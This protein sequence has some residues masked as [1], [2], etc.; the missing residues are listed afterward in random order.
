MNK[1]N[2]DAVGCVISLIAAAVVLL[3]V[4]GAVWWGWYK[5]SVQA[6]V[7]RREGIEMTT[8]E[9]WTGAKPAERT[10]NIK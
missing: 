10:I 3:V 5:A 1:E 6:E 9:V 8:W 2:D 4:I 7:Y